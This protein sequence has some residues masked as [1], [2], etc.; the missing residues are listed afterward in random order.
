MQRLDVADPAVL[1]ALAG[2]A[3][4]LAL[5]H[6]EPTTVLG[7]VNEVD[8]PHVLA[9]H[10]RRERFV[11]RPLGVRVQVVADQRDPIHIR[12]AGVQQM[13]DFLSPIVLGTAGPWLGGSPR[14][15]R[16]T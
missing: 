2:H 15:V 3:T 7:G 9:G 13:G 12:V 6:V 14:A 1:Q 4:Q 10:L 8:P 16:Q 11:E 5:R